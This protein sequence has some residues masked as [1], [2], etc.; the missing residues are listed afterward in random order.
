LDDGFRRDYAIAGATLF[1]QKAKNLL[2][3]GGVGFV[4]KKCTRAANVHQA[5]MAQFFEMVRQGGSGDAQ[6]ILNFTG[7]HAGGVS[8]KEQANNLQTRFGT[9]SGEAIAAVGDKKGI[10]PWHI[11]MI[12]EIR[13]NGKRLFP[14]G[15]RFLTAYI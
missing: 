7:D 10:W 9:E 1:V 6:L 11:S 2:Q 14:F 13:F 5:D 3:R 12:A 15:N 8:G 4:P